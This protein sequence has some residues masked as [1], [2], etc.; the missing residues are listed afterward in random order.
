M[1]DSYE[2]DTCG[3][4]FDSKRG[5]H[6]HE[7]Q[8][9]GDEDV[10]STEVENKDSSEEEPVQEESSSKFPVDQRTLQIPTELALFSV[11]V[12]GMA[13][14]LS[15]GILAA[16]SGLDFNPGAM[17]DMMPGGDGETGNSDGPTVDVSKINTSGEPVLGQSDAPVTMVVYEDL[18]CPAC[19]QFE[20]GPIPQIESNHVVE[21][22]V[23]I[24]WKDFPLSSPFV[25]RNIHPWATDAARAM[26]CVYRQNNDAFWAVK[27]TVFNNQD[28]I[29]TDNVEN[30]IIEWAADE[31]IPESDVQTCLEN[32][33][34]LEEVRS[35]VQEAKSF[36][37][38]IQ[39]PAGSR[40]FV[41][42]T[43]SAVVYGEGNST[44]EPV[45]GV[46]PYGAFRNIIESKLGS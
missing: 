32:G 4:E 30:Q 45:V 44:G 20:Q 5:L 7:G 26:E 40:P 13:V 28:S 3:E 27:D 41:S 35:D 12:L 29:S 33:N 34:P 17:G 10:E 18:Q 43:P 46:Q 42:S 21:G 14:G 23:K 31:G 1:A 38:S 16:G 25:Q 15:T 19:R 37:A 6:I 2:C 8:V 11:F 39:T 36:D 24:I 9:H 22:E